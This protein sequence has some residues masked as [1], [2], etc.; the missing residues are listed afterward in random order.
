MSMSRFVCVFFL[1]ICFQNMNAQKLK[2]LSERGFDDGSPNDTIQRST[3]STS[4][5]G[6]KNEDATIYMYKFVSSKRDTTY[7]DTTLSIQKEYKYNYLRKDNFELIAFSNIGQSYNTLSYNFENTDV[8][9]LFAARAKHFNYMEVE[10]VNY[11][12]VPTPFSELMYKTAFEQGQ[13]LDAF[14]TTNISKQFNFSLAYKGLRSLGNYQHILTSTGN[15]RFTSNYITK[16]KRYQ[17]RA[18]IYMQD[19]LNQE[20]GGLSAEGVDRFL[21][22]EEEFLDRSVFDPN[23]EDAE[24]VLKGKRFHL[25]H[26]YNLIQKTDSLSAN[27]L[28]IGNIM[29]LEDKFYRYRQDA[30]SDVLG[31]SFRQTG[32]NDRVTL[33]NF[34]NRVFV[35]YANDLLGEVAFNVDYHNYNYGYDALVIL[36]G[37]TIPNR[38]KGNVITVGGAYKNK[39]GQFDLEGDLGVNISGNFDGNFL[40][41]MASY[42]LTDDIFAKGLFN[43]NS[44]APNFNWLLYQS[45]YINYNWNK[46]SDYDNVSTQQLA[47]EL[48]SNKWGRA[49]FDYNTITNYAYFGTD[50]AGAVKPLQSAATINYFRIKLQKE[51][52]FGNFALDNTIMYQEVLNGT[53]ILN[54]P[55]IITRNTLYFQ[56]HIFKK[57]LLLQ[58]GI[59]FNY[60][61]KYNMNAYDPVLSEFY[62][63]NDTQLGGFPRMDFFVNAKIRQTRIFIKAEHFNSGLTG[64]DYFSAPNYPYRDFTIRFGVVWNFFL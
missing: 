38:L 16:S 28:S 37:E 27:Q 7:V 26:Q 21:S 64:Y 31:A 22:G 13:L 11:F 25:E 54:V 39:I 3:K 9:P 63:Q 34:Y 19:I 42:Q 2:P 36:D 8:M 29:S 12:Q 44:K 46:S 5:E 53:N 43:V 55:R 51:F 50:E 62:V 45:D 14:F 17:A 61:T 41:A 49:S 20:N 58:T 15:F 30:Q 10:D 4:N 35:N 40:K 59:I 32:L 1:F 48:N 60:F 33:E 24:N 23:F 18:H 56:D 47:F 52:R 6:I 57:S